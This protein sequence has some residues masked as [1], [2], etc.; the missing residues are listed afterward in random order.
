L[1]F[2]ECFVNTTTEM[3]NHNSAISKTQW[4]SS[5]LVRTQEDESIVG[6]NGANDRI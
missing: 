4:I 1:T 6:L 3:E 2:E 5:L